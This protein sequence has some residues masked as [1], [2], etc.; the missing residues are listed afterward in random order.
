M[1]YVC[2]K[3]FAVIM[4][5]GMRAAPAVT[6]CVT[7][8]R[9]EA[10]EAANEHAGDDDSL[11]M[12]GADAIARAARAAGVSVADILA[13]ARERAFG[14]AVHEAPVDGSAEAR[15]AALRGDVQPGQAGGGAA[16][17]AVCAAAPTG[18]DGSARKEAGKKKKR[19]TRQSAG[20]PATAGS[21]IAAHSQAMDSPDRGG[22]ADAPERVAAGPTSGPTGNPTSR[23]SGASGWAKVSGAGS[24]LGADGKQTQAGSNAAGSKALELDRAARAEGKAKKEKKRRASAA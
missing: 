10:Y 4:D 6:R 13:A 15:A 14:P 17:G 19:K 11:S 12:S 21:P 18:V 2:S 22:A 8:V 9:E 5:A 23:V 24:A 16:H 20:A 3:V 7:L 1:L